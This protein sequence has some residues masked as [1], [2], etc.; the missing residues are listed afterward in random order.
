MR[1]TRFALATGLVLV[2]SG[3]AAGGTVTP[4][5]RAV[6]TELME[7]TGAAELSEQIGAAVTAQFSMALR[8][9]YPDISPRAYEIV[10]ETVR[11]MLR[12]GMA[13]ELADEAVNV[14]ARYFTEQDLR[15]LLEFYRSPVGRKVIENMPAVMAESMQV[16][17]RWAE[18][19]SPK[20]QEELQKR[21][22]AAGLV[23]S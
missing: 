8:Q 6:A 1:T 19:I 17:Q 13:T 15:E 4:E 5:Y 21:L 11:E 7:L 10:E 14:Y 2:L 9:T 23:P 12:Q 18:R 3:G 22:K 16:G 20:L